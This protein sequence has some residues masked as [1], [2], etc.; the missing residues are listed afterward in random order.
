L[1]VSLISTSFN[2]WAVTAVDSIDTMILMNLTEEYEQVRRHVG[3][4]NLSR[5]YTPTVPFFETIIRYLGGLLSAYHLTHDRVF[6]T[7]ADDLGK[8]LLPGFGTQSGLPGH[9]VN[10]V[11][12]HSEESLWMGETVYLAEVAS[13]QMEY[14]Y[15]AYLTRR[16]EYFRKV[17]PFQSHACS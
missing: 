6:L 5:G 13:C 10:F 17:R 4:L 7:A 8:K 2:G 9:G 12:D 15:L 14:K 16:V 3:K 11:L 1:G